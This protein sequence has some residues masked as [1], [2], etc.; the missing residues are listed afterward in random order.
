MPLPKP[1][2]QSKKAFLNSCMS[3]PA[4]LKEFPDQKQRAA[5]CY[6]RFG[7]KKSKASYVVAAADDEYIFVTTKLPLSAALVEK[8]KSLPQSSPGKHNVIATLKSGKKKKGIISDCQEFETDDDSDEE[9]EDYDLENDEV[10]DIE[11]EDTAKIE[12]K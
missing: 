9:D 5:V 6:Q 1:R 3:N 11:M 10:M 8:V 12:K 7:E 2:G 4:M